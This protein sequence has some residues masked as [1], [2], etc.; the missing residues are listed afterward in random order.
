MTTE[1]TRSEKNRHIAEALGWAVYPDGFNGY[2][3]QK[4]LH[5]KIEALPDFYTDEAANA[6]VLEAMPLGMVARTV[7]GEW[8]SD[9]DS[10]AGSGTIVMRHPERKTAICEAFLTYLTRQ[11]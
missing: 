4:T 5:D 7:S 9:A 3:T 11:T 6:L 10:S 2:T 1:L 8:I